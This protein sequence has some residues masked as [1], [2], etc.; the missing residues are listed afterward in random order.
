MSW[1]DEKAIRAKVAMT[2]YVAGALERMRGDE[3]GQGSV[4]YVGIIIVVVAIILAVVGLASGL[5][6]VIYDQIERAVKEIG[7][8]S[9]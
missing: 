2:A 7:N 9:P 1:I 6:Q 8:V 3:R 4:E 5:G